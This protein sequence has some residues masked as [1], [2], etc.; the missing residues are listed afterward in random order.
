[1]SSQNGNSQEPEVIV[2]KREEEHHYKNDYESIGHY[3]ELLKAQE[4]EYPLFLRVIFALAILCAL[5]WVIGCVICCVIFF[6][7][8]CI[9][10]FQVKRLNQYLAKTWNFLTVAIV[11][12]ISAVIALFS[13]PL[14][15][16]FIL[17]FFTLR[18]PAFGESFL[19]RIIK[20]H[21]EKG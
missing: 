10:L 5:G 1:M 18:Q 14:G 15:I 2:I 6:L 12:L 11:S 3:E 13:P 8:C 20:S 21:F 4:Q 17:L 9:T 16:G 7:L 19:Q